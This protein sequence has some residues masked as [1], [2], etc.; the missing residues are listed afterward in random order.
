MQKPF[1]IKAG[2]KIGNIGYPY[3]NQIEMNGG[4]W[5]FF[6]FFLTNKNSLVLDYPSET[7]PCH[8]VWFRLKM[9]VYI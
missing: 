1:I 9:S 4:L 3:I 6:S 2:R 7:I 8:V 5:F